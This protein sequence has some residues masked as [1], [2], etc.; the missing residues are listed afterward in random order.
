MIDV[1]QYIESGI[2]EEY[3][4]GNLPKQEQAELECLSSTYP[5][6]AAE[7]N[8]T[9]V[10]L[11]IFAEIGATTPDPKMREQIWDS[12]NFGNESANVIQ[13]V[14]TDKT[15][16]NNTNNT[17]KLSQWNYA[18]AAVLAVVAIVTTF[19]AINTNNELKQ[20]ETEIAQ[21]NTTNQNIVSDFSELR[22][23][24]NKNNEIYALT[25][26]QIV[27]LVGIPEKSPKSMAFAIWDKESGDVYLDVKNLPKNPEGMQYQLWTISEKGVP[28]SVGVFDQN[29]QKELMNLGKAET[30]IMFAVTLEKAGGVQSP[31]MSEMYIA[32][33]VQS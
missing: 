21:L 12:L 1:K 6:I 13:F 10:S 8:E 2:I 32:G 25:N 27:K 9:M 24:V 20:A 3:A 14:K 33:K 30:S 11:T 19:L 31:T 28:V 5:E 17:N 29:K 18:V 23:I 15:M 7:L 16:T 22:D 26:A 4:L